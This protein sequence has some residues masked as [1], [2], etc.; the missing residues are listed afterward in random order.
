MYVASYM[1]AWIEILIVYDD[2]HRKT[3]A[4]YM[5]AW[6]EILPAPSSGRSRA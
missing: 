3:V 6:I 5:D 1:D 2:A 4:S